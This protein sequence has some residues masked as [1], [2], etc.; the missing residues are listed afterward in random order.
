MKIILGSSSPRRISILKTF[1]DDFEIIP[2]HVNEE[3]YERENPLSFALRLSNEKSVS[4]LGAV[5][6]TVPYLVIT[7]DTIV[8]LDGMIFGKPLSR[9]DAERMLCFLSGKEH[10][11]ITSMTIA[12][13]AE[14]SFSITSHESS[15]VRFKPLSKNDIDR[16]LDK[17]D[18]LDKAGS[19]AIQHHG[20]E[21]IESMLGSESN[22]VGFPV[23][24]FFKLLTESNLLRILLP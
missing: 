15:L 6:R 18:Y 2:P 7:A 24:L 14:S 20:G 21:I 3:P 8:T 19:Y 12:G 5:D 17:I 10:F 16:Y 4:V 22:I 1:F 11:V 13:Y 23:R 9:E